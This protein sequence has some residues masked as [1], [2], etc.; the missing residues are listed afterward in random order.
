MCES[1]KIRS[2]PHA[3]IKITLEELRELKALKEYV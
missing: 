3:L 1:E 2:N